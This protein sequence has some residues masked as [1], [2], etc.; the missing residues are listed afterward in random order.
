ML[1]EKLRKH[2]IFFLGSTSLYGRS[3]FRFLAQAFLGLLNVDS[4]V[5]NRARLVKAAAA[6]GN[7]DGARRKNVSDVCGAQ[8]RITL[9]FFL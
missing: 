4:I 1:I 5:N 7:G 8:P 3:E 9:S 6:L 2:V